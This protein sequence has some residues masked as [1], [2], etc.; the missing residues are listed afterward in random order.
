VEHNV[1]DGNGA[2]I[3]FGDLPTDNNEVAYNIITNSTTSINRC[4]NVYG[5]YSWWN[6]AAPGTGNTFHNNCLYGN[7]GG[8]IEK[9]LGGFTAT[10]NLIANPRYLEVST[11]NYALRAGSPC[12]GFGPDT[13]QPS[14]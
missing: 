12:L 7:D 2:G 14:G 9:S 1:I 3:V 4:C 5:V 8:N 11:R 13:A 6:H 10:E